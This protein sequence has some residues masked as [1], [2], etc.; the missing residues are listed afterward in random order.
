MYIFHAYSA[1]EKELFSNPWLLNMHSV[2]ECLWVNS[3]KPSVTILCCRTRPTLD[4]LMACCLFSTKSLHKPIL[5]H[6]P[7]VSFTPVKFESKHKHFLSRKCI[8]KCHLQIVSQVFRPQ[9]VN[10]TTQNCWAHSFIN[11]FNWFIYK[12]S[13][14]KELTQ[15][16]KFMGPSWGPPENCRPHN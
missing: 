6:Y 1:P 16:A 10:D 5:N 11:N 9:C 3:L 2:G 13:G 14:F 12:Q 15:I 4:Q 7:T 8:W